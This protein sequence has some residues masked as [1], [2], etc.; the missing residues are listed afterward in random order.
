MSANKLTQV[1]VKLRPLF[2][3]LEEQVGK[4]QHGAGCWE[5]QTERPEKH[6]EALN[7]VDDL[8]CEI[9]TILEGLSK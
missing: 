5:C 6:E 7:R 4:V 9:L 2:K 1:F 8:R 3:E